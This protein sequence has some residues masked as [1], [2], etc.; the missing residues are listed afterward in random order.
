MWRADARD[1]SRMDC[2]YRPWRTRE[3]MRSFKRKFTIILGRPRASPP[4]PARFWLQR[5]MRPAPV[6]ASAGRV[7]GRAPVRT[8]GC[9]AWS[10]LPSVCGWLRVLLLTSSLNIKPIWQPGLQQ[11]LDGSTSLPR[12][13]P[14]CSACC[15]WQHSRRPVTPQP[16]ATGGIPSRRRRRNCRHHHPRSS[17]TVH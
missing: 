2:C 7:R 6:R 14:V 1:T 11:R 16:K 8:G 17:Q 4:P 3:M 13:S 9:T 5:C 12:L 10:H 15:C